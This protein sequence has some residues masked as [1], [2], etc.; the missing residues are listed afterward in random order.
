[1]KLMVGCFFIIISII[2]CGCN[3]DGNILHSGG[4]PL[5][6]FTVKVTDRSATQAIIEWTEVLDI[7]NSDTVKYNVYLDSQKISSNLLRLNDTIKN[8]SSLTSY[9]GHVL[10]FTKS[11]DTVSASFKIEK[12]DGVIVFGESADFLS[13]Y[14]LYTED[15]VWRSE[16]LQAKSIQGIPVVNGDT[17]FCGITQSEP[18]AFSLKTGKRIWNPNSGGSTYSSD[19]GNLVYKEGRLFIKK[20]D[21]LVAHNSRDGKII[22]NY[23]ANTN[24]EFNISPVIGQSNIFTGSPAELH[25][26][27]ISTG[28]LAWK[29]ALPAQISDNPVAY[30]NLIVFGSS[31]GKVY[32]LNQSTGVLVWSRNFSVN[33]NNFGAEFSSP[34]IFN[35]LII[36]HSGNFGVL[37]LNPSNGATVW[38]EPYLATPLISSPTIGNGILY[39]VIAVVNLGELLVAL[40]ALDGQFLWEK[41]IE[42]NFYSSLIYANGRIYTA[43]PFSIS[44][45]DGTNGNFIKNIAR[46]V[47]NSRKFTI[48]EKDIPYY[49]TESGMI[50]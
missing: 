12:L 42:A 50:N 16:S 37:A 1:M 10:A 5:T 6:S 33:F 43:G 17:I 46:N 19:G 4:R 22:W 21:G 24:I 36:V 44:V 18:L 15:R 31:N 9:S 8:I 48:I 49:P 26:I 13:C 27:N 45:F 30:N 3:R 39:Y 34:T 14:S 20:S 41:K 25:A 47:N 7:Y 28:L 29:Y 2:I 32:A 35:N 23:T 11:G 40:N 38:S